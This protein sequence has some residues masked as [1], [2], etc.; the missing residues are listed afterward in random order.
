[1]VTKWSPI[2]HQLVTKRST[3]GQQVVNKR[4]T[5]GHQ[6]VTKWSVNCGCHKLSENIWFAWSNTR[7]KGEK[8]RC[9]ACD[10]HTD[11]HVKVEQYSA[12]AESAIESSFHLIYSAT[13]LF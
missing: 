11:T 3:S 4:S 9:H 5:S 13:L 7:Y 10:G 12:E 1:M 2:G 8:V 6:V